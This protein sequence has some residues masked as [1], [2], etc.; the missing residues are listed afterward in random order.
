MA[1]YTL[2][3]VFLKG[4]NNLGEYMKHYFIINPLSGK[5]KSRRKLEEKIKIA[6]SKLNLDYDIYYTKGAG[7]CKIAAKELC[8]KHAVNGEKIRLYGCGGDGTLNEL[9]NGVY[10]HDNV[11]I[12]IIPMGTGNDYVRNYGSVNNFHN[13]EAQFKGKSVYSDLLKYSAIDENDEC[14]EAFCANMF[15]IG[16]DCNAADLT[17]KVKNIPF[18]KGPLAYLVAVAIVLVKKQGANLKIEF[19]DGRVHNGKLLLTTAANGCYC[20]GGVKGAPYCSLNDGLMDITIIE[21]ISRMFFISMFPSYSKGT[22]LE[23]KKV[24]EGG[25]IKYTKE[26]SLKITGNDGVFRLCTDGEISR[27]K[28]VTYS[29]A[30]KGFQFIV[31]ID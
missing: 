8:E 3:V 31:P 16:F 30:E 17:E 21:D 28:Q 24:K 12:G 1:Y 26:K 4:C 2:N 10:G 15:N 18:I 22:H 6:A 11:E 19:E 5:R 27:Q 14:K 9:V 20:G 25:M 23:K 7:D 29:V 13:I